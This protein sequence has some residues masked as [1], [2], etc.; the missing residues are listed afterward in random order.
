MRARPYRAR[1]GGGSR[2]ALTL[3]A[4][5]SISTPGLALVAPAPPAEAAGEV[6]KVRLHRAVKLLPLAR[7]TRLGYDRDKFT[8]W[9]DADGD[10][11][12][13]RD[14]VLAAES[15]IGVSGCDIRIGQWRSYYDGVLT[16][17]SSDFDVDHMVPLAEAWDSGAKRWSAGTRKAFANDLRDPRSLVAVT[18]SSN[19]SKSDQDPAEWLPARKRCRYIAEWTAVKLRWSLKANRAERRALVSRAQSCRNV[20]IRVEKATIRTAKDVGGTGGGGGGS[21]DPRFD[22]C[23]QAIAAGYGPY[24]K[25][26]DEEYYWYTDGDSDGIACE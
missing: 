25:G 9:V 15:L 8:H 17:S 11:R 23:Y 16:H 18:A 26:S 10:C 4:A 20:V 24:Y 22:Y 2:R 1:R 14:E 7:E 3:V 6:V 13:T 12:D 5:L 21:T 19:R